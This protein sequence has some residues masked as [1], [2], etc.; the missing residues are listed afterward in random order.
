MYSC[1]FFLDIDQVGWT[2]LVDDD[3]PRMAVVFVLYILID[4][5]GE[6]SGVPARQVYVFRDGCKL[7][8]LQ[9]FK[10]GIVIK[11]SLFHLFI[12]FRTL[13]T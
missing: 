6:Y 8:M 2:T 9:Y 10:F 11:E 1:L 4:V 12:L 3:R 7:S 5:C 13:N